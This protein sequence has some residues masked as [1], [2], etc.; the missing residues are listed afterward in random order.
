MRG[1]NLYSKCYSCLSKYYGN[2]K[3]LSEKTP[4]LLVDQLVAAKS[5]KRNCWL[6]ARVIKILVS[7]KSIDNNKIKVSVKCQSTSFLFQIHNLLTKRFT[8]VTWGAK[9]H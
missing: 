1:S 9:K 3:F 6:R 8:T 5:K 2:N 4:L 7:K